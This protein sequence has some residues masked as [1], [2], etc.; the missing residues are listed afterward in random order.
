MAAEVQLIATAVQRGNMKE[1]AEG[2]HAPS[3]QPLSCGVTS[4]APKQDHPGPLSMISQP[5]NLN[6]QIMHND[7]Q[8]NPDDSAKA[9][10]A[11]TET[12]ALTAYQVSLR[13]LGSCVCACSK[14]LSTM[15]GVF[16]ARRSKGVI[17]NAS[18]SCKT[19]LW[20]LVMHFP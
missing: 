12:Q 7:V 9:A 17:T 4:E 3:V 15:Q 13:P 16:N 6:E 20:E 5:A 2:T 18:P 14:C 1:F 11:A 19:A 8:R 10:E